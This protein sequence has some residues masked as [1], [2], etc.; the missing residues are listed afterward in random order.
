MLELWLR[1]L[2]HERFVQVY[3]SDI[4][5]AKTSSGDFIVNNKIRRSVEDN[6]RNRP[7]RYNRP[8]DATLLDDVIAIICNPQIYRSC[9]AAAL[10]RAFPEGAHEARTFLHRLLEPRNYLAHANPIS[11]RQAEQVICYSNDVIYA[12]REFYE[13]N[14]EDDGYNVPRILRMWD[15]F[16]NVQHTRADADEGQYFDYSN[17]PAS[18]LRPGD[19][20]II[21]IEVDPSFWNEGF[22]VKWGPISANAEGDRLKQLILPI[23][24]KH[25]SRKMPII[26]Q[27]ISNRDW[28]RLG[29]YFD[30][31]W[32]ASY[33]VLQPL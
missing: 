1:R 16:G 30:D 32:S 29:P 18:Y 26:I 24:N 7:G 15:S 21:E 25:V 6:I 8:I 11:V 23:E 20:L 33:R 17:D 10:A 9:F 3:A 12:L 14:G 27:V 28:H 19:T 22:K 31:F 13:V 2:V 5:N 4:L